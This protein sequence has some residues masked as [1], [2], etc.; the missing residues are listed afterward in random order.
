[1]DFLNNN[2]K[3]NNY[4]KEIFQ[5]NPQN[6]LEYQKITNNRYDLIANKENNDNLNINE[7]H[8]SISYIMKSIIVLAIIVKKGIL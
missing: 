2:M 5:N 8:N 1:M 7:K 4:K 3:E 6:N